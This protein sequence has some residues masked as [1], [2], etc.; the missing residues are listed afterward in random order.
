[1][2]AEGPQGT[3]AGLPRLS[4]ALLLP[5]PLPP[6]SHFGATLL[7]HV[8]VTGL[9][10]ALHRLG[11]PLIEPAPVR[12][13][14]LR[15]YLETA[16]LEAALGKAPAA[17]EALAALVDPAGR[18]PAGTGRARLAGA[19]LA[20]RLRLRLRSAA[21]LPASKAPPGPPWEEF[22]RRLS[23]LL[24]SL[25][26]AFLADLL[27]S[28]DRRRRRAAD[29]PAPPCL[30]REAWRF[31]SGRLARLD[32]L[33]PPEP[34]LPSWAAD[35]ARAEAARAATSGLPLPP[36][37]PLRGRFRELYRAA[38]DELVPRYRRLADDAQHRGLIDDPTDAFFI[39][40]DLAGDLAAANPP[41]WLPQAVA[42]NRQEYL[43]LQAKPSP[44]D[45]T[46]TTDHPTPTDPHLSPL[47]PLA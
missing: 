46:P 23:E 24:P 22:R 16:R 7:R 37:H 28:L 11:L 20:H 41:A 45:T 3:G 17:A 2:S 26:D 15:L 18:A 47:H 10:S 34:L 38:L 32:R 9:R 8:V 31:R 43:A 5:G 6:H 13:V 14:E 29:Q 30:G 27:A 42:A 1:M 36:G 39:P 40:F 33:G 19:A 25:S 4:R 44:P 21:Q 35:P 12:F